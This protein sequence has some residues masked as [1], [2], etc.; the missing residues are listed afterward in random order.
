[1]TKRKEKS[2]KKKSPKKSE[3]ENP[4][5]DEAEINRYMKNALD[6]LNAQNDNNYVDRKPEIPRRFLHC[7]ARVQ[8][9]RLS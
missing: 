3:E 9:K 5:M 7:A 4:A 2:A 6:Q 8:N 1:M